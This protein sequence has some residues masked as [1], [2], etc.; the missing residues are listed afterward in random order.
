MGCC[1]GL[2]ILQ[3]GACLNAQGVVF[4]V[5]AEDAVHAL[6]REHDAAVYCDRAARLTCA[7]AANGDENAVFAADL[8]HPRDLLGGAGFY[9]GIGSIASAGVLVMAVVRA[10]CRSRQ[11][12][13]LS[14]LV[15]QLRYGSLNIHFKFTSYVVLFFYRFM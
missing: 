8:E 12:P 6:Y 1:F 2:H 15:R 3:K 14:Q 13:L 4:G 7:G 5:K 11:H 10:Y 9:Y